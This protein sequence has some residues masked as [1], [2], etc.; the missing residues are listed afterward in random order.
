MKFIERINLDSSIY[1][2]VRSFFECFTKHYYITTLFI[3]FPEVH[4]Y[5]LVIYVEYVSLN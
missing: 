4:L 1:Q 3:Y 2:S 5:L